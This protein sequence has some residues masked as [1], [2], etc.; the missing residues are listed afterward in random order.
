MRKTGESDHKDEY[1]IDPP[2]PV[3]LDPTIVV[4]VRSTIAIVVGILIL[5]WW[6]SNW[7]VF[8]SMSSGTC[9]VVLL[10]GGIGFLLIGYGIISYLW[11]VWQNLNKE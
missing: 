8:D 6:W 1:E 2:T 4:T 3:S 9:F 5:I 10:P 7:M 11:A